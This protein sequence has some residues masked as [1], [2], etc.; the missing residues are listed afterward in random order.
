MVSVNTGGC[1]FPDLSPCFQIS[2]L[3]VFM[4]RYQESIHS[5]EIPTQFKGFFS[6]SINRQRLCLSATALEIS[7]V[8]SSFILTKH[9]DSMVLSRPSP[10]PFIWFPSSAS[11]QLKPC[12]QA[13]R[14]LFPV[15]FPFSDVPHA[16]DVAKT[17][18]GLALGAYMLWDNRRR[19]RLQAS[20]REP[21]DEREGQRLSLLDK[22]DL[23]RI[24]PHRWSTVWKL[25]ISFLR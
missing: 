23:V 9:H 2:E 21:F 24:C 3:F 1:E 10:T 11:P 19:D 20:S 13:V 4:I 8:R 17:A 14:H 16:S 6:D 15:L 12:L 18:A 7:S 5:E 25:T 22:T